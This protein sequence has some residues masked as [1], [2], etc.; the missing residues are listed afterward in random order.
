MSRS[1]RHLPQPRRRSLCSGSLGANQNLLQRSRHE[2][3]NRTLFQSETATSTISYP[4]STLS[5]SLIGFFFTL[6]SY[7]VTVIS[8][9]AA[10]ADHGS[11]STTCARG[12]CKTGTHGA[13]RAWACCEP[14]TLLSIHIMPKLLKNTKNLHAF[15][16]YRD[17]DE[18]LVVL[19][20][21]EA[22]VVARLCWRDEGQ[23]LRLMRCQTHFRS[24]I[25][26]TMYDVIDK[27]Q[28]TYANAY[29]KCRLQSLIPPQ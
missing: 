23:S 15:V 22:S 13:P 5:H 7:L 14:D 20:A 1:H 29:Q 24:D 12:L 21:R 11:T 8:R 18:R 4:N 3:Q 2:R 28:V 26:C 17:I 19:C 25:S 9:G 10:P 16:G 27:M 6:L